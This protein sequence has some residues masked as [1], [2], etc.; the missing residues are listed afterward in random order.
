VPHIIQ[1]KKKN[2][3]TETESAC[4]PRELRKRGKKT[5]KKEKKTED[6]K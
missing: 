4:L 2:R 1:E 3:F 6:A 5:G